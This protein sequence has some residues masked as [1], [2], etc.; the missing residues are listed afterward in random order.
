MWDHRRSA[1]PP[2]ARSRSGIF[3]EL[4]GTRAWTTVADSAAVRRTHIWQRRYQSRSDD[5]LYRSLR[6]LR[7]PR[8]GKADA[9]GRE[10]GGDERVENVEGEEDAGVDSTPSAP[11]FSPGAER[12]LRGG[13][14][15]RAAVLSLALCLSPSRSLFPYVF[16]VPPVSLVLTTLVL[17]AV[18]FGLTPASR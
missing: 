1:L 3:R 10:E 13:I 17:L 9:R 5:W 15:Q 11:R 16:S 14:I 12:F 8:G 7:P 18:S 2:L 6:R 4:V